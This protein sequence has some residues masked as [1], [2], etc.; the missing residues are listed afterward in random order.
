MP[1]MQFLMIIGM[2]MGW[3]VLRNYHAHAKEM[4]SEPSTVPLFFFMPPASLL[5]FESGFGEIDHPNPEC[6]IHHE[7]ELVFRIGQNG[8]P[9]AVC[10][11]LDLTNRT[12]QEVAKRDGLPWSDAKGFPNSAP[13]GPWS[14]Y[15]SG[16]F[17]VQLSVNGEMRQQ[18]SSIMM[19]HSIDS[20]LEAL[21]ERFNPQSGDL[22]FTGTPS[23]VGPIKP[24]DE[25]VAEL[26][27]DGRCISRLHLHINAQ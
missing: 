21:D 27:Q 13:H 12:E 2:A 26:H 17:K 1:V 18:V 22:V 9:D 3:G 16:E 8:R 24:G 20:I 14:V 4:G 6:T 23:G 5:S 11:G 25:L 7:V 19:I 10:I 15:N